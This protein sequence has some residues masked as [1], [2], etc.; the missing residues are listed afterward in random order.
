MRSR[1]SPRRRSTNASSPSTSC[2]FPA[3]L[4]L[5]TTTIENVPRA[6]LDGYEAEMIYDAQHF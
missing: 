5:C 1:T 6:E 2:F 4:F 3:P